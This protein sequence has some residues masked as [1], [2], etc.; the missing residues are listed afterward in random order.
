MRTYQYTA[1]TLLDRY[2]M[3]YAGHKSD[4]GV[5]SGRRRRFLD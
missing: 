1:F 4:V 5:G 3:L 2:D